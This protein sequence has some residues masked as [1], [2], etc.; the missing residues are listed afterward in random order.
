MPAYS[1]PPGRPGGSAGSHDRLRHRTP[2]LNMTGPFT[3]SLP[4]KPCNVFFKIVFGD[5]FQPGAGGRR[6]R[7]SAPVEICARNEASPGSGLADEN[8]SCRNASRSASTFV[9]YRSTRASRSA[10]ARSRH[11][12]LPMSAIKYFGGQNTSRSFNAP[13][14]RLT[15][16][17]TASLRCS[18]QWSSARSA[19]RQYRKRTSRNYPWTGLSGAQAFLS[20]CPHRPLG[21]HFQSRL[22]PDAGTLPVAA[23]R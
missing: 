12:S 1:S 4:K 9:I 8:R 17:N 22:D 18:F 7:Q 5:P 16:S 20:Q 6:I 2:R 11:S 3:G 19:C 21:H 13:S 10:Q 14:N 23:R 15:R